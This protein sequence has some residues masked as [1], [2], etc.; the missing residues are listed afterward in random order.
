M[1]TTAHDLL[2]NA[3]L[4]RRVY[5]TWPHGG[6]APEYV[7]PAAAAPAPA[8]TTV[9]WGGDLPCTECLG[10]LPAGATAYVRGDSAYC[11]FCAEK[12]N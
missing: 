2:M 5:P 1:A 6:P 9:A 12:E 4:F 7:S 10:L 11:A 8:E 3:D